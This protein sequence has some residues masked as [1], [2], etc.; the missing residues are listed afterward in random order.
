MEGAFSLWRLRLKS[1]EKKKIVIKKS[2]NYLTKEGTIN[3]LEGR[4]GHPKIYTWSY[5][6]NFPRRVLMWL[7]LG[8]LGG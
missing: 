3:K 5:I 1:R 7:G 6:P 2:N 4:V 8:I